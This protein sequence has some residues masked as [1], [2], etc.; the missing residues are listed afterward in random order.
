MKQTGLESNAGNGD[1]DTQEQISASGT[2]ENDTS[3]L[4]WVLG[5]GR[6]SCELVWATER[7]MKIFGSW[8]RDKG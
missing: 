2:V 5:T 6:H 8:I 3:Y 4:K 1:R 7:G